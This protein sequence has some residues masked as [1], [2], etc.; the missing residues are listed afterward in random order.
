MLCRFIDEV[1]LLASDPGASLHLGKVDAALA[2]RGNKVSGVKVLKPLGTA[3][4]R[5]AERRG[6]V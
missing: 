1:R 4:N 6:N 2:Q 3:Q 5:L